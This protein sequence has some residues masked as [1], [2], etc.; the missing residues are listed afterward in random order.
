MRNTILITGASSG[1]GK[2]TAKLF[3]NKGWNVVATMRAPD[4][5]QEL[6]KLDNV[7]V[8]RLDV[9]DDVSIKSAIGEGIIKFGKIEVLLNNA[10][11]GAFGPLEAS[12][13]SRIERQ[14]NT[15]VI[16]LLET[17]KAMLSHFRENRSGII[18]NISSVS[19]KIALPLGTLY[20][21]TKFAVE[22]LSEALQYELEPIGIKVKIVEPGL[23][24][25]DFGGR[26]FDFAN[27]EALQEYQSVVQ[28]MMAVLG[29]ET[30]QAQGSPASVVADV[31][32]E[33]VTDGTNT[34]R[35][36]AG[37]DAKQYIAA[38]KAL[39]DEELSGGIRKQFGL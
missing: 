36:T 14:F 2:A 24:A 25:T 5:E 39:S 22:G 33:A 17:T 3:Q 19:G 20:H 9:T 6:T 4:K 8:T 15:N 30:V 32:W 23:I 35:Y 34:L 31:I 11:Y 16:G 21:G 1:I 26:S 37:E 28:K 27:D 38:R 18:V 7:L 13:K 12:E 29:N 10:G